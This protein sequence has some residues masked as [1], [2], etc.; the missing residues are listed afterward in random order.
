MSK[1]EKKTPTT[2]YKKCT[3]IEEFTSLTEQLILDDPTVS[4][5]FFISRQ[6]IQ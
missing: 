6:D 1:E 5:L 3:S 2:V 4:F